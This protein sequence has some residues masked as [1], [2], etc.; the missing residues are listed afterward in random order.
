MAANHFLLEI[1]VEEMP[2]RFVEGAVKQLKE[3]TETWLREQR[4]S[5]SAVHMFSTPR[6][7]ALR[8]EDLA[9]YQEDM[10]E[11]ARGPAK[12]LALTDDGE[13]SKAALGFARGQQVEAQELYFKEV[14]GTEYVFVEKEHKGRPTSE[15]LQE[16]K[17]IITSLTFPKNMRWGSHE[18]RFV[19]PIQWLVALYGETVIPFTITDRTAG[20]ISYGHRFLGNAITIHKPET[21][22]QQLKE[23]YVIADASER[24]ELIR[25]QIEEIEAENSWHIPIDQGLLAEVNQLVEYPTA[26]HGSFDEA[27]L[28]IP[29][30]VLVTSMKEHQRYFPVENDEGSL[31]SYFITVRNGNA[32]HLDQVRKGN[33][34]VLRARLADAQFFYDEDRKISPDEAVEKLNHVIYQENLGTVGEKVMRVEA[35]STRLAEYLQL[36]SAK[37]QN[38]K[39]AAHISKFDLVTLMVDEFTE[40]Q[41]I[42]GREY[43]RMAGENTE[44]AEAI[45]EHYK[46]KSAGDTPAENVEG[47]VIS[48]V[49]KMDTIVSSFGVGMVP[50]GSQDPHGLRRQAAGI[51]QTI[52]GHRFP[53][54]IQQ[55][56]ALVM[57]EIN[58]RSLLQREEADVLKDL[59][60]FFT[61][62]VR[63][64]LHDEGIRHDIADAVLLH[65]GERI[66]VVTEKAV[67]IQARAE[68]ADFKETVEALSRVTNIAKNTDSGSDIQT[69]LFQAEEEREL[70]EKSKTLNQQLDETLVQADVAGAYQ[71]L[72]VVTPAIN[73]YFDHVMVMAEDEQV[74]QNRLQQM[75]LLSREIERF[76]RFRSIVFSS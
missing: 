11:E 26:L 63:Q 76:A 43:A 21:Y 50:T 44:V 20:N 18:L 7:L 29:R 70:Y 66:D 58:E 24:T 6:R 68:E 3:K 59:E 23:E 53:L 46:P 34:K 54:T 5:Y 32:R 1:G 8:V 52:T 51:V 28:D 33:E 37:V 13:W 36:D 57:D 47:A 31:L 75:A 27:Y 56:I 74:K 62:R 49:D 22:E 64:K 73:A 41:G 69:E 71:A 61:Q 48:V 42:M 10:V 9:D 4:L 67:F 2:A 55:L 65:L 12:K 72:Q 17:A 40:L 15:M 19:R 60:E 16:M 45:A 39:R 38:V 14:K 35:V 25:S 30:E